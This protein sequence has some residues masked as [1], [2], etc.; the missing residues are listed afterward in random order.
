MVKNQFPPLEKEVRRIWV[1]SLLRHCEERSDVAIS[2]TQSVIL[3][4]P[5]FL[6]DDVRISSFSIPQFHSLSKMR[7]SRPHKTRAQD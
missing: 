4:S 6:P 3:R 7:S 5:E 2:S 1:F